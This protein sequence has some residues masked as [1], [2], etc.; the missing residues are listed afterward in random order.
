MLR[1]PEIPWDYPAITTYDFDE[2]SI[3]TEDFRY[4]KYIDDGEELYDHR[5][6]PNEF[7]NLAKQEKHAAVKDELA[8][9]LPKLNR[10]AEG[11]ESKP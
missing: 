1:D 10:M 5:S 3:R 4:I 2:F 6:D 8:N 11:N 7:T 9:W